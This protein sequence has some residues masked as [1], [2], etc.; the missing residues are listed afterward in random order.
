LR[1]VPL[2]A[3]VI[4]LIGV[5]KAIV[6]EPVAPLAISV[7]KGPL[8]PTLPHGGWSIT[9][10]F[11]YYAILPVFLWLLR[12]SK[13]LP[14]SII[15]AAIALRSFIYWQRG[16]VQAIAYWTIVGRIDQFA[17]GMLAYHFRA[18]LAG[19]HFLAVAIIGGFAMFYWC[20]DLQGGFY[21]NPSYPSSS[22]LWILFPTIEAL[23]YASGIAWYESSFTHSTTGVSKF[24][25]YIGQYSYSI[26]LFHFFVVFHAG[27]FVNNRI[28]DL[29]NFYVACLWSAVGFLLMVP[30]GYLSFRLI[31][32]PFL[33]LRKRYIVAP[34]PGRPPLS[35]AAQ[36]ATPPDPLPGKSLGRKMEPE[37]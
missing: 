11:H 34:H 35:P 12:K 25:G 10:E 29:S 4:L 20:F 3:F 22:P 27:T 31:E 32:A 17:L 24:V 30:V 28:M 16:E 21:Q 5:K 1:L 7:L 26:Y 37:K 8:F 6:G 36:P 2:L 18:W 14:L 33:K 13:F 9:V 19:R 15:L 23:A